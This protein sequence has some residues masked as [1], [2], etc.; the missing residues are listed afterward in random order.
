MEID[1][2]PDKPLR[3]RYKVML[4]DGILH[5]NINLKIFI[6]LLIVQYTGCGGF[7]P[8]IRIF[9]VEKKAN[10]PGFTHSKTT[11]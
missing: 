6:C 2:K 5:V 11:S 7:V 1:W 3:N 10:V 8:Y 9:I 4:F